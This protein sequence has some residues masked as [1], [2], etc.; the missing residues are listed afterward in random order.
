MIKTK[1]TPE[2]SREVYS[3]VNKI[4]EETQIHPSPLNYVVWYHYFLGE[5]KALIDEINQLPKGAKSYND[6][7][8]NRLYE[9]FIEQ[10]DSKEA[11][12][13]DYAVKKF[14]DN[15]IYQMNDFSQGVQTQSNKIGN[16]AKDMKNNRVKPED[17]EKVAESILAAAE[18]M[19]HSSEHMRDEVKN[20]SE[21]V[22][23]LRKQ[24]DEAKKEAMT[25]ELTQV[26]NRKAF[27]N[28]IQ[29]LTIEHLHEPESL[30]LI[31][32][33]IDHFKSFND[34]YGH[35]VGDSVL[36]YFANIIKKNTN[37]NETVCRYGGE[38]FAILLRGTNLEQASERAEEIRQQIEAARLTLKNSSEPIRTITASFGI[39]HFM[40][41]HDN[42]DDF[43]NR[44]D[45]SLYAAKEAGR[46]TV[47]HEHMLN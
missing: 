43:I 26:G 38:E 46:N 42:L 22:K 39:S 20:S 5:N 9:E 23:K 47:I 27:N 33:D 25:D 3:K 4:F 24:L 21:E 28:L 29:D 15:I 2:K 16:F 35:P 8:G 12:E 30:C 36:R 11:Q 1:S 10:S 31:M 37:H 41:E 45:K 13:Y 40:G 32:T 34:T 44:A 19:Q 6:R 14:F 18:S 7:L 17:I